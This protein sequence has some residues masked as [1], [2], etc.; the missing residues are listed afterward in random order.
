M[1]ISCSSSISS[2]GSSLS[3]IFNEI[4]L[5]AIFDPAKSTAAGMI[6]SESCLPANL[7]TF[8]LLNVFAEF[9]KKF[10]AVLIL[11]EA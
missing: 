6:L 7:S 11:L 5:S 1:I 8:D 9:L 10:P 2:C 4:I 3:D